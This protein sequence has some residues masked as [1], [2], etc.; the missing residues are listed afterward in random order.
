MSYDLQGQVAL[1]TGASKGIG[2]AIAR[3]LSAAGARVALVAR[4]AEALGEAEGTL[5]A[6]GAS[7]VGLRADVSDAAAVDDVVARTLAEYGTIDVLVNNAATNYVASLV[8]S[9]EE[10]WRALYDVNVF[11]TF[12]CTKAV[13]RHMIRAKSGRIINIASVAGKVGAS[14]NSAY[15]SSKAAVI[16]FTKSVA[17]EV[18]SLGITVNAVCPWHVDT[19]LLR[20]SM[21]RRGRMFGKDAD[22]YIAQIVED[23]P[24]KRLVTAQE[25]ASAVLFLASPA[26]AA[27]TGQAVDVSGGFA[28]S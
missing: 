28:I 18:A 16:G 24:Q 5:R 2:L 25:V 14:H 3:S 9:E 7:V 6:Q 12:F 4:G 21:G 22:E 27:V 26:A 17:R 23:S 11:G 19:P 20:E 15:A 10:R 1:I 13:L 8:M